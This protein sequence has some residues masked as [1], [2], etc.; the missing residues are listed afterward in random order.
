MITCESI[1]LHDDLVKKCQQNPWLKKNGIPFEDD[2]GFE[3]DS[4]YQF[5][6]CK[7]ITELLEMIGRG[8][9]SIRQGFTWQSLAFV[10]QVNAGDEWW[11]IK[12]FPD[13]SLRAFESITFSRLI[14]SGV[15]HTGK[16]LY[17]L[18]DAW[19]NATTKQGIEDAWNITP[20][21]RNLA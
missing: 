16:R 14:Q 19:N 10:N 1:I 8:N 4:P 21:G 7:D 3:A 2:P 18:L 5:M 15:C 9:W 20:S 13:G 11:T 17:D 12:R 6:E